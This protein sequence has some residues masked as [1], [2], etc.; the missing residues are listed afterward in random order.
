[1]TAVFSGAYDSAVRELR[2]ILE[3]MCQAFYLDDSFAHLDVDDR[4]KKIQGAARRRGRTL[5]RLLKLPEEI[6]KKFLS[7]Y[8]KLCEYVHPSFSLLQESKIDPKVVFFYKKKWFLDT[9]TLHRQACDAVFYLMLRT[10]PEAAPVFFSRLY[11]VS[12]LREMDCLLTLSLRQ[13]SH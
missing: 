3:D 8:G 2:F 1:M 11:V 6:Q 12:S 5:I 9:K 7:L 10:F 13:E 4:Y